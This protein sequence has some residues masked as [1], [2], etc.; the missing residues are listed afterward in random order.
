[1]MNI[2]I[3]FMVKILWEFVWIMVGMIVFFFG[4]FI[5]L[6]KG[7]GLFLL[8]WAI[9]FVFGGLGLVVFCSLGL[10]YELWLKIGYV[11]GWIN[12]C[13]IL[14]LIFVLVVIFMVLVMKLI[15]RDIMVC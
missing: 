10:V 3:I 8:F 13:I 7:Y 15:K 12:S 5:F 9:V 1:M 6:L 4:L 11:L 2:K 14:I